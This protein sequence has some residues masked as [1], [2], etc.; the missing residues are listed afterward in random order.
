MSLESEYPAIFEIYLNCI[1]WSAMGNMGER[2]FLG[3]KRQDATATRVA[4]VP[5]INNALIFAL[6]RAQYPYI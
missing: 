6:I 1:K 4:K 3:Y 2:G 5:I